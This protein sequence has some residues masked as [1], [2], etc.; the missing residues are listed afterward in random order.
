MAFRVKFQRCQM[1]ICPRRT[2]KCDGTRRLGDGNSGHFFD[3]GEGRGGIAIH[4]G[5]AL[6]DGIIS[7]KTGFPLL[8]GSPCAIRGA[9]NLAAV[10]AAC[11]KPHNRA[12]NRWMIA[13][14]QSQAGFWQ[15]ASPRWDSASLRECIFT[16]QLLI[17]QAMRSRVLRPVAE[18]ARLLLCLSPICLRLPTSPKVKPYFKKCTACHTIAQGGANGIGPNLWAYSRQ[19]AWRPCGLCLF[20]RFEIRRAARGHS[21]L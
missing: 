20:G 17:S 7:G 14:T 4:N 12:D 16:A 15:V 8:H 2:L 13:V 11:I 6:R 1:R 19:A 10:I 9:G 5:V 21:K 3:L 18:V